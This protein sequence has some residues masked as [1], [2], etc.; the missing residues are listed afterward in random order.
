MNPSGN[1]TQTCPGTVPTHGGP[2]DG[3]WNREWLHQFA[4]ATRAWTLQNA[5]RNSC[6][7]STR[8]GIEV[9]ARYGIQARPQPV[10]V[11][12]ANEEGAR[13]ALQNVP[14]ADWP[15][16]A[17][18]VGVMGSGTS[19]PDANRWDG[20]LVIVLRNPSRLRTLI[21]I[22]SDQF[23]RPERGIQI[24]GP[25]FMDITGLWSPQDPLSTAAGADGNA[26]ITYWVNMQGGNWRETRDWTRSDDEIA[27]FAD[28][29]CKDLPPLP[30]P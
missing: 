20:H 14:V 29:I 1:Q 26:L 15:P 8:I 30:A 5:V 28:E 23:S 18:S 16:T 11:V 3:L 21:D 4:L 12:A 25:V 22:T 7:L 6:V 24:G 9:L 2:G 13:L 19:N 17:H 27:E 10:I